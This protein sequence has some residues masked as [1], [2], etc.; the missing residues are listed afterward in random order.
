MATY[1]M[2]NA[3][4]AL[5]GFGWTFDASN[6][7]TGP[8][9]TGVNVGA[10]ANPDQ[11]N[12]VN[13]EGGLYVNNVSADT[14]FAP[15]ASPTFTGT[16]TFATLTAGTANVTTCQSGAYEL[17]GVNIKS[18]RALT[19]ATGLIPGGFT[20]VADVSN[21]FAGLNRTITPAVSGLIYVL[22]S[23][24]MNF[25]LGDPNPAA[26]QV[27]YGTGTIPTQGQQLVN[28]PNYTLLYQAQC[29]FILINIAQAS[30]FTACPFFKGTVG[31]TYWVDIQITPFVA[32]QAEVLNVNL[33]LVEV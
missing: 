24:N 31:T 30:Y 17:N 32:N 13:V 28:T 5:G 23:G 7:L 21:Q 20:P 14:T 15:L 33:A 8:V 18:G 26:F 27:Y 22:L 12:S 6:F 9:G 2:A 4:D 3:T 11:P 10:P 19:Q 25:A 1:Y 16:A 29:P